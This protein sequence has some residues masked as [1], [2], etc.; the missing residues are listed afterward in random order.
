MIIALATGRGRVLRFSAWLPSMWLWVGAS[1]WLATLP[2]AAVLFYST[3]DPTYNTSAPAKTLKNSGWQYQGLW[4]GFNGTVI[5]PDCFITAKHVGG[6]V[7]NLFHFQGIDYR[8]LAAYPDPDSDLCIWR[9]AGQFPTYAPLYTK[10]NEL[11][12]GMVVIG[13]GTQR[14]AELRLGGRLRGWLWGPSDGVQRWGQNRVAGLVDGGTG[15]GSLLRAAFNPGGRNQAT[16]SVGDSGG[17]VFIKDGRVYKLAGINH[18]VDGPYR[19]PNSTNNLDAALFDERGLYIRTDAGNWALIPTQTA[20]VAG[21]FYAT[22][23]SSRLAWINSVLAAPA[24]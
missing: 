9:V 11:N 24:P 21:N 16:L 19:L 17:A 5:G 7:G 2:A 13:R 23:I 15:L 3:G 18:A 22:R 10:S 6:A 4:A 14:G 1:L 12:K 20:R 8:T